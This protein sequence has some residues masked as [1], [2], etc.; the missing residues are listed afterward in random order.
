MFKN[1]IKVLRFQPTPSAWRVTYPVAGILQISGISTHTLRV[2][3][4]QL[5]LCRFD[6]SGISTHTLRVEGDCR[7][8]SLR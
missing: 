7:S 5:Y 4:D 6:S 8:T 1:K 3:G 2:E